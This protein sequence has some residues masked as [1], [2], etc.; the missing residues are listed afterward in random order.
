MYITHPSFYK[1]RNTPCHWTYK[2]AQYLRHVD[3]SFDS[4]LTWHEGLVS[5]LFL[6]IAPFRKQNHFSA[7]YI[8]QHL[9]AA[10]RNAVKH[11]Y[12]C[13]SIEKPEM[14]YFHS[15]CFHNQ[16]PV[17]WQV[18]LQH[19]NLPQHE[20]NGWVIEDKLLSL[21]PLSDTCL[22]LTTCTWTIGCS[23]AWCG[24]KPKTGTASC[25]C[26]NDICMHQ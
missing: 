12:K 26:R 23:I 19:L 18:N 3:L 1:W 6:V 25:K 10:S 22:K 8:V 16:I 21:S 17:W 2:W 11:V 24:W 5:V 14:L 13:M 4:L 7:R 20:T 15:G 9:L